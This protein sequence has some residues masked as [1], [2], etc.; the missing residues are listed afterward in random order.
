MPNEFFERPILNSPYEYPGWHWEL[1]DEG[2]PTQR[3]VDSRRPASFIT[4][5][6]KPKKRRGEARQA[7]LV[8]DEG[9]GLSTEE[10]QYHAAIINDVRRHVDRWRDL[11]ESR[12]NVTPETA[13]LL[14][15]WR[16]HQFE[17]IRPFFCQIEAVETAIW[18]SEVAPDTTEGKKLIRHLERANENAN[19][20]LS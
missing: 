10:Q 17:S 8:L 7:E 11:P 13:R 14:N 2:Q 19:P 4:P 6:P 20:G 3:K 1:D 9:K 16:H 15:Y 12:W 5:I 18:L